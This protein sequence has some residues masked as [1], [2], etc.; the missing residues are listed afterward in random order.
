MNEKHKSQ[1]LR[2]TNK[3]LLNIYLILAIVV[4][5]LGQLSAQNSAGKIT[6]KV[7]SEKDGESLIGVSVK[8]LGTSIGT[9]TDING[10]FTLSAK[11]GETLAI[12]YIGYIG[13]RVKVTKGQMVIRLAEDT[14][15]LDE[16]IVIGYGVQKKK[17][18][19]GATVQV[20]GDEL[21]K[22]NTTNAMPKYDF[23]WVDF[24]KAHGLNLKGV[25]RGPLAG[26]EQVQ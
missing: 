7:T 20:K 8:L 23:F 13:Q 18:S 26:L 2:R 25:D 1:S 6:G 10:S 9:I 21:M 17:L 4:C 11:E 24:K 22:Q 16:V 15:S 12:S 19:T 14:K 3:H 5:S